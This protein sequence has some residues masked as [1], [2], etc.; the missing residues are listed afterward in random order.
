V[1]QVT[2]GAAEY[3]WHPAGPASNADPAGPAKTSQ[4]PW[5]E[6]QKCFC[7]RPRSTCLRET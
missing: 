4:W 5:K 3:L 1:K 6:G 7:R 2:F